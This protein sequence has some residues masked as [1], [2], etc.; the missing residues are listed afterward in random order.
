VQILI[1]VESIMAHDHH[2]VDN[3]PRKETLFALVCL[4][5]LAGIISLIGLGAYFRG[6]EPKPAPAA[7]VAAPAPA[8]AVATPAP[9]VEPAAATEAAPAAD[10]TAMASTATTEAAPAP[11]AE[12]TPAATD[13]AA[14]APAAQ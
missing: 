3:N 1:L 14:P 7:E 6:L 11:A 10:A 2:A 12:A 5:M 13:A 9:A 4:A 8:A